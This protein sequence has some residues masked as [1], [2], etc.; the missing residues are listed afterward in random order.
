MNGL[1]GTKE[2][3]MALFYNPTLK[4][5][6][7]PISKT[8]QLK[9]LRELRKSIKEWAQYDKHLADAMLNAVDL[10]SKGIK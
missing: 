4:R 6:P 2:N 8:A 5:K 9:E 3:T 1:T 7:K 10:L